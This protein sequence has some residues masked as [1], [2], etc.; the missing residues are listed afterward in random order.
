M[1]HTYTKKTESKFMLTFSL[2]NEHANSLF[3]YFHHTPFP[4][5][6]KTVTSLQS[7]MLIISILSKTVFL[8]TAGFGPD[9]GGPRSNSVAICCR[10]KTKCNTVSLKIVYFPIQ[11]KGICLPESGSI[12][13]EAFFSRGQRDY[14]KTE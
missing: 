14:R 9:A 1:K 12:S 7:N 5:K 11:N 10:C 6:N 4:L 3:I 13:R 2:K 8:S